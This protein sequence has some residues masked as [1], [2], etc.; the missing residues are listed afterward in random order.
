MAGDT[1]PPLALNLNMDVTGASI[2]LVVDYPTKLEK[3]ATIMAAATGDLEVHWESGDLVAGKHACQIEITDNT[4]K[5][6]TIGDMYL[7]VEPKI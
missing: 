1:N 6:Q 7:Q 3:S 4:G 2:K 5:V